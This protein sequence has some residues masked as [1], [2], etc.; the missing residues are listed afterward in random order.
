M[1][2][3][4]RKVEKEVKKHKTINPFEIAKSKNIIIRYLP[5]GNTLGFYMKNA[6]QKVITLNCDNN[7]GLMK[8]VCAHELGHAVIHPNE[9]TPFLH[10][11]TLFSRDKIERE[12]NEFAVNLILYD[13]TK[14]D[15]K[16]K[17]DLLKENGIP[18]EME[19]FIK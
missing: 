9:N 5:L 8:F 6:R 19:R 2:W 7:E 14:K 12:A 3:I 16:T 10:K 18:Y 17:Y 13:V 1:N 4:M 15:Y 11:N